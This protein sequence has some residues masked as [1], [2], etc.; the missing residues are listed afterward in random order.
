MRKAANRLAPRDPNCRRRSYLY[1]AAAPICVA[2]QVHHCHAAALLCAATSVPATTPTILA[3]TPNLADHGHASPPL[4]V[5]SP[6]AG[7]ATS[8]RRWAELKEEL[9]E[10][11]TRVSALERE[12]RE[13]GGAGEKAAR[14]IPHPLVQISDTGSYH[15]R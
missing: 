12:L 8:E 11:R 9:C 1:H 4:R 5:V 15:H 7:Y 6:L 2:S 10:M 14:P 3:A 13:L